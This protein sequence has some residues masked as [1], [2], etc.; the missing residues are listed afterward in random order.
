MVLVWQ[1][2]D[3]NLSPTGNVQPYDIAIV[4]GGM[5][6]MALACSLGRLF[7]LPSALVYYHVVTAPF[8]LLCLAIGSWVGFNKQ[9]QM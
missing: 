7:P 6:G 8:I 2:S 4:G 3:G 1:E 5:V 9:D